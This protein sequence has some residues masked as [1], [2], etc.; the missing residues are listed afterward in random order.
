M[1]V[2]FY[3]SVEDRLLKFAVIIARHKGKWVY[4]KHWERRTYE[5]PGGHREEGESIERAARRELWEE[6]G[7]VKYTISPVCVYS[8]KTDSEET[9]GMLYCAEIDEFGKKA[10]SEIEKVYCLDGHP[11]LQ[12]YPDIQPRLVE[13]AIRRGKLLP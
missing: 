8:V 1:E 11:A 13:E 2:R 6:T 9:F 3:D 5:L 12:T 4:C 10:D 7:A